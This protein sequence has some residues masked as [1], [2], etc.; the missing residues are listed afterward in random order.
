MFGPSPRLAI[1]VALQIALCAIAAVVV[2]VVQ[3]EEQLP[4]ASI[5]VRRPGWLSAVSALG[6]VLVVLYLLPLLTTPLMTALDLG[7]FQAG[8]DAVARQPMWWRVCVALTSGPVEEVLYRGYTVERLATLTGRLSL[9]GLLATVAF[10]AAHIPFW[11]LGPALTADLPF[12][13]LMTAL[14][15]WRR[16]LFANA[17]AHTA[18]L[19]IGMLSVPSLATQP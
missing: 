15:A 12:G 17:A 4:I 3:R 10:G 11:G 14:Y 13:A 5:G 2:L 16:D 6:T 18:L 8:L 1:Q 19:L 9:G 7:D